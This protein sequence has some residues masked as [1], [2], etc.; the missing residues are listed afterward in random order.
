MVRPTCAATRIPGARSRQRRGIGLLLVSVLL[1]GVAPGGQQAGADPFER[2]SF[3]LGRWEGTSEGR[4]GRGTVRREYTRAL[5]S[6]FIRV[7]NRN[8]YPPQDKNPQ[9]EIHEDEG[10]ISFDRARQ[11]LVLRQFHAEGFVNE[12]RAARIQA[13]A[14]RTAEPATTETARPEQPAARAPKQQGWKRYLKM[15]ACCGLPLL[16]LVFLAGGGGALLGAAGALL[17]LLAVLACPLGMYFMMRSMAKMEHK[18]NPED[19][20]EQK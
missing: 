18:E 13:A 1:S 10:F 6:R 7:H 16:A 2:V 19:K 8:E 14:L 20:R 17:P 9:G 5:N 15:G 3:L 11:K 4:P 12:V